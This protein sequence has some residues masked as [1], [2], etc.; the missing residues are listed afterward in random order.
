MRCIRSF[1]LRN[2]VFGKQLLGQVYYFRNTAI[3]SYGFPHAFR[4]ADSELI[5]TTPR[6]VFHIQGFTFQN[7]GQT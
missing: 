1:L 7:G 2:R 6:L 4:A 3:Q 5:F